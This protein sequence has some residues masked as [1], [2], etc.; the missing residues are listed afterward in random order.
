[1]G[2]NAWFI[3]YIFFLNFFVSPQTRTCL[4]DAIKIDRERRFYKRASGNSNA[5]TQL[6]MERDRGT[7]ARAS[8]RVK[9]RRHDSL[10][11]TSGCSVSREANLSIYRSGSA[12]AVRSS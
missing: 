10:Y 8:R 11:P 6:A 4:R 7:E 3:I 2:G 1:M 5:C 9:R 12:V